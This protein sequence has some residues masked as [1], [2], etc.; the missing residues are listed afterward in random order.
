MTTQAVHTNP[1]SESFFSV[2]FGSVYKRDM[3]LYRK[4]NI[5]VAAGL[6]R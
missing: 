6:Y 1:V 3:I 2:I 5:T 4:R